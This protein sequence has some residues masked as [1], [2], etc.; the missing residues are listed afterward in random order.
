MRP[1]LKEY[2]FDWMLYST[3]VAASRLKNGTEKEYRRTLSYVPYF[4]GVVDAVLGTGEPGEIFLKVLETYMGN[5]V[6]AR[7]RG[8][9]TA[10]TTFCFSPVILYA[11]D[12]YPVC[13]EVLS[14]LMTMT[15]KRGTAE[16][17]DYCNEV[18]YTETSCSSQRGA[19][20]AYLAGIGADI[21][22]I[23]TDSPGVC[24]TNANAFAF[25]AAYLKKPFFQLDMPPVLTGERSDEYHLA[26]YRALIRFL[27]ENTGRRLDTDKL[28]ELLR[29]VE[30]QE[31]LIGELEDLARIV[32]NPLPV[33]FNL[34]LYSSRFMF[35][36]MKECTAMLESMLRLAAGNAEKGVAGLSGGVEKMRA[37]FCYIDHYTQNLRLWQFLDQHGIGYLG[38]ILS[39]SW[40]HNAP[41][42]KEYHTEPAAYAIDT[43]DLDAMIRTM[44]AHNARMPM[45][46]SI[47]GPYDGPDMWLQDTASLAKMYGADCV[48]YNG[49]PGCRNTWGMVKLFARDLEK[50]GFPTFIMYGDAFDDRVESWESTRDRLEEFLRVRR[51]L[52]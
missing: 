13:L 19:I 49:T 31:E 50:A 15:Y 26:D 17:L 6:H 20:G 33:S 8:K 28:G 10:V 43:T 46:K 18:G 29:E 47:R 51:L 39:R 1:E 41:H 52:S 37:F 35:S 25:A 38:N 30:H 7:E 23:V 2:N 24:D 40:H 16:F 27:E 45:I 48:I 21:D 12:I 36:G 3:F 14:V 42:V 4:S 44:A 9:H 22:M 32:P 5:I 11:M 34:L